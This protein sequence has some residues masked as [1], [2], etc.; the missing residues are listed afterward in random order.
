MFVRT[1]LPSMAALHPSGSCNVFLVL[2]IE[3][4]SLTFLLQQISASGSMQILAIIILIMMMAN[5][6]RG[7][8]HAPRRI[9][10]GR[11]ELDNG[12]SRFLSAPLFRNSISFYEKYVQVNNVSW[13]SRIFEQ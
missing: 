6:D 2:A 5:P 10:L 11:V 1:T 8:M 12:M 13:A 3:G 4:E 7:N 9:V